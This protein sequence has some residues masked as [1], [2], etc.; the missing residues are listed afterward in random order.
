LPSLEGKTK[1]IKDYGLRNGNAELITNTYIAKGEIAAV[2]GETS[3]IW[4]QDDV[5]EFDRIATQQNM[6]ENAQQFEFYV[7]GNTPE[8]P[9]QLHIIPCE[10]AELALSMEINPYLRHS[11]LNRAAWKGGGQ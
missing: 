2:F 10:D 7:S 6:I 8:Y 5:E 3:T 11:L 4:A 9:S 1:V